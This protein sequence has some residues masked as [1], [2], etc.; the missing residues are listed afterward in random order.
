[1]FT[2]N[3]GQKGFEFFQNDILSVAQDRNCLEFPIF[4]TLDIDWTLACSNVPNVSELVQQQMKSSSEV[5]FLV[6]RKA[7]WALWL[8]GEMVL[9]QIGSA[10]IRDF[11]NSSD[12][13]VTATGWL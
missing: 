8:I 2:V 5:R 1:M 6:D 3:L 9:D 12:D 10:Q 7:P 11:C 4:Y 13:R